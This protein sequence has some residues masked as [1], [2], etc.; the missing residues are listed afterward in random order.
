[1]NIICIIAT[2]RSIVSGEISHLVTARACYLIT[3]QMHYLSKIPPCYPQTPKF[4]QVIHN[5]PKTHPHHPQFNHMIQNL[6]QKSTTSTTSTTTHQP[7]P[8]S[9]GAG[10]RGRGHG[11]HRGEAPSRGE[12]RETLPQDGQSG[13]PLLLHLLP[14]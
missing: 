10:G 8:I 13:G 7:F 14:S 12:A 9:L 4:N 11:A 3:T 5:L 1:M 6:S 2:Q